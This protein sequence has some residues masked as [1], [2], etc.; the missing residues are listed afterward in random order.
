VA[1][2]AAVAVAF[3]GMHTPFSNNFGSS[4]KTSYTSVPGENYQIC[5]LQSTY[6]T[7]PWTYHALASGSQSYTVAQYEALAGYGT[8]LPPLPAYIASESS[9]TE[10]AE[11]F[12][13]GSTVDNPQYDYPET[14]VLY[15]FEG[16]AYTNLGLAA[17]SGDE[18][19]G[20]S[21]TGFPEPTFD[22]GGNAG[23][24]NAQNGTY[25]FSGG[26]STLTA[27]ANV[28]DSII[29][30]ANTIPGYI[31]WLT[32]PDGTTYPIADNSGTT[33]TLGSTLTSS[34]TSGSEAWGSQM[35]PIASVA[36]SAAQGDTSV[37]L[38]SSSVPLV[39]YGK[40]RIGADAYLIT[41]VTGS[42]SSG[43]NITVAGL[44][45]PAAAN[46]PVYYDG[47]AGD[48]TVS[49]LDIAHDSH[50]TTGTIYTGTGWTITHNN[51][52][53]GYKDPSG[54]PTPGL[55]VAIYGGDQGTIEYNCLSKMGDYGIQA[56]GTNN[57]FDYNEVYESNYL[58]DPGCGC[59]GG[60]KWW[61]TL[62]ADI[63]DNAFVNDSPGDGGPIWLDNGN[64]GTL[65]S[66][67]YFYKSY[68]SA[69]HSE[70]GFNLNIT[71]NLF[72]DGGWGDGT[73]GC[74]NNCDGAVNI[75]SSGGFDV[76]GSRYENQISITSNQFI[77]NW[78]GINIWQAG[79]RSCENSGEGW[80]VDASYCSG[81]FPNSADTSAG[82]QYYFSHIGDNAYGGTTTLAQDA[83]AGS[84]TVLVEGSMA[85][86]DQIGFGSSA[87]TSTTDVTNVSSF[88]GSG[89]INADT[90]G[91][92]SS[93]D[94]AVG[95][96]DGV[97]PA[98]LSYTGTTGSSFTGVSLVNGSGTLGG[99]I[100]VD[101]SAMTTTS[102]TT[103][104][105][106]F[107]G[108]TINVTSTAGFP[109]TGGQLRVGTSDAWS[110]AGGSFTGGILS[111]TGTTATSFTGVS[112]VRG[113]GTLSGPVQE[114]QPYKV[115]AETCY[116]N[117]C[118]LTVSPALTAN[119][120]AG[121][122]V[123]N[124]GTCQL[125]AT[126][127]ALPSGPLA[128]NG[129]SY[130]DGC[131][132]EARDVSVTGNNFVVQPSLMN[133]DTPLNGGTVSCTSANSCGMNF[134][135]DQYNSGEAP[136]N[137]EIG[138]NAMVSSSS[139]TGCPAWDGG[140]TT[141]PLANLNA[142]PNP[143]G[144]VAGNG[145]APG[146]N[147]W[148]GNTYGGPWSWSTYIFGNCAGG[149]VYMPSDSTTGKSLDSSACNVGYP[150]WQSDWQQDAGSTY[151]PMVVSLSGL[152]AGQSI[153]GSSQGVTAYE[154]TESSNTINSTLSVNSTN[155]AT[156]PNLSA[157]PHTFSLNTLNYHDGS[158]TVKVSG[159]DNGG[160]SSSDS[161]SVYIT[162]GDFN[163][164]NKVNISDLAIMAAHW[165][166][167]DS[168]YAHGNITGQ[169]TINISDLAVLAGNWGG[170]W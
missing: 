84:S 141:N 82:G 65:I 118:A 166:Q 48:V 33:I 19:I 97:Y 155:V 110:D 28:G 52:H 93:G 62:N 61:G 69:V 156:V 22:D 49:Y 64:T 143:P 161:A 129:T 50:N 153:H 96:S 14:P 31:N 167:T 158:Y 147:V 37:S 29:S 168:N 12:A 10:A 44:D 122:T 146:N 25:D 101:N 145:E 75:N 58:P 46:T 53:D 98:V 117:D 111:Y 124:S 24:I 43:Y 157:S 38:T 121:D 107:S 119:V 95:T 57:T 2:I 27:T 102:D 154:D 72:L 88:S 6:L 144:A 79:G 74:G 114:V 47:L 36:T 3:F 148:S 42:Q 56:D 116:A 86:D 120:T 109:S 70:T 67:N 100:V 126:A 11:V 123:V 5:D 17:I 132:W 115:T 21:A 15:F 160:N 18:F 45:M 51:I 108:G 35:Q 127:A 104:I 89:T 164:D 150:N 139:F 113:S 23:G 135:A 26:S 32:F 162:N 39:K 40:V 60:G 142:L 4:R 169:S 137:T 34:E 140:C 68:G 8:T 90:T 41:G 66:G 105:S 59:S 1:T 76:P 133:A 170:S 130:W 138:P 63:V 136:F 149:G 163:S 78:M 77:N 30:V 85:T 99:S 73:G 91:F 165:G 80:P 54:T 159:T 20:G 83:S 125:F 92:P 131:Q 94:I 152:V 106:T 151:N 81:G 13:P 7:S 16:G 87:E 112:F 103:N 128:P 71:G 134:M 55:G 9:S